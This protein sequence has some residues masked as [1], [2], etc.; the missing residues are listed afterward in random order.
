VGIQ[1][2]A[3]R[4]VI[5]C[6]NYVAGTKAKQAHVIYSDDHGASWK[7][8]GVL[9]PDCNECQV[10]ELADGRLML[11]MRSY[12]K[13]HRRLVAL[14]NDGGLTWSDPADDAAL[15]EPVCQASISRYPGDRSRILFSNP[16]SMQREKMT[17]RLSYDEGRTWPV[18]RE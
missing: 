13:S 18:A 14:S 10:V 3:G 9:G 2:R 11:N 1:T 7:L 16:A 12:R 5:P 4:L 17:V 6:D 8:G 15:V